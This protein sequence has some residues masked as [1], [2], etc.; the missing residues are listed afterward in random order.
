MNKNNTMGLL[1][2]L[3]IVASAYCVSLSEADKLYAQK[4]WLPAAIAYEKFALK[5]SGGMENLRLRLRAALARERGGDLRNALVGVDRVIRDASGRE[6]DDLVGEA[7]LLK[8]KLLHR[9]KSGTGTRGSL[10]K[11]AEARLGKSITLSRLYESE[12]VRCVR[13]KDFRTAWRLCTAP[14]IVLSPMGSNVVTV[15]SYVQ[16]KRTDQDSCRTA[17]VINAVSVLQKSNHAVANVLVD[18]ARDSVVGVARIELTCVAAELSASAGESDRACKLYE[19]MLVSCTDR[20]TLQRLRLRYAD[21]LRSIGRSDRSAEIYALWCE[22][23][24]LGDEYAAGMRRYVRFLVDSRRYHV[25]QD[26]LTKFCGEQNGIFKGDERQVLQRRISNGLVSGENDQMIR[27][28][29][30]LLEKADRLAA[31]DKQNDAL[32]LY[33]IVVAR[34]TG[35]LGITARFRQGDCLCGMA[36][37]RQ[38]A[39]TWDALGRDGDSR[40]KI[41]CLKRKADMLLM[42]I[43]DPKSARDSYEEAL[44]LIRETKGYGVER[45]ELVVHIAICDVAMGRVDDAEPIFRKKYEWAIQTKD[46]RIIQWQAFLDACSAFRCYLHEDRNC[47]LEITIANLLSA[48]GRFKDAERMFR[49][50]LKRRDLTRELRSFAMMQLA[51]CLDR[52]KFHREALETYRAIRTSFQDCRCAPLAML[53]AGVLCVGFLE[54]EAQG[55]QYFKFIEEK[56]PRT[57]CAETALFYRLTLAI[58][59]KRW[60]DAQTLREEFFRRHPDSVKRKIVENE[61]G[62]LIARRITVLEENVIK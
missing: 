26:M 45:D 16:S 58:W 56:W 42:D 23:I 35:E 39:E 51:E 55:R 36:K 43:C 48:A 3:V 57:Q 32:R 41:R 14:R 62:E 19:D 47:N 17:E 10:L 24:R 18:W 60:N 6:F 20:L 9:M 11:A 46:P 50:G 61:Y 37:Y 54:D 49:Q 27:E 38:A 4:K 31:S 8:Q 22:G 2:T 25:A 59:A 53:R 21:F 28:G 1:G 34:H 52:N 33:R 12:A 13:E 5:R 30:K 40:L 44:S 7:F 29:W 15:L